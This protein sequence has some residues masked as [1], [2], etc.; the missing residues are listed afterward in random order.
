MPVLKIAKFTNSDLKTPIDL[1]LSTGKQDLKYKEAC[2]GK[3]YG[4]HSGLSQ[5]LGEAPPLAA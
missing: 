2:N 5:E 1:G 3:L 4:F